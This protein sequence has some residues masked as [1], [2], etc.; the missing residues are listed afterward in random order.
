LPEIIWAAD[1]E[2]VHIPE[3][4]Q[5]DWSPSRHEFYFHTCPDYNSF[6]PLNATGTI[7][8]AASP[9]FV[10]LNLT[11][12]ET[13]CKLPM[14]TIWSP[15]GN[16]IVFSG[17]LSEEVEDSEHF[18]DVAD[19]WL[20]DRNGN[21]V[22]RV[23]PRTSAK[24]LTFH[25]W[26]DERTVVAGGWAGGGH[27]YVFDL[28]I[29]TGETLAAGSIHGSFGQSHAHY[30]PGSDGQDYWT[31]VSA[32]ALDH[33]TKTDYGY[34]LESGEHLHLLGVNFNP[35]NEEFTKEF[36]SHYE[37]WLPGTNQMLVLTWESEI[38]PYE[39]LDQT[40]KP[41]TQLQLWDVKTKEL[42]KLL[43]GNIVAGRFAPDG[44]TL[45]FLTAGSLQID[46]LSTSEDSNTLYM[47]VLDIDNKEIILSLPSAGS[48]SDNSLQFVDPSSFSP[49]G[50]YLSVVSPGFVQ[51]DDENHFNGINLPNGE[52][53][54]TTT[55]TSLFDIETRQFIHP[56]V[57]LEGTI[58]TSWSPTGELFVFQ[59]KE[60]NWAFVNM[61][62]AAITPLTSSGGMR[63]SSPQ[64]SYDG[65]YLSFTVR[66]ENNG[67]TAVIL[68][69]NR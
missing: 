14:N 22:G 7:F 16:Y 39:Y 26:S 37:D 57:N 4:H 35:T 5:V 31:R 65:R 48:F 32:V 66:D 27:T 49:N 25:G 55:Y 52:M 21:S 36:N 61:P 45:L 13:V 63:L 44:K 2:P 67:G 54:E 30:V 12:S 58:L 9:D 23:M 8:A 1:I 34:L 20:V 3:A 33:E 59:N 24:W 17:P 18:F 60:G 47:N 43:S 40:E 68:A 29:F 28:D 62:D 56:F 6:D 19:V 50:R 10:P 42:I 69:P 15:D 64:W 46:G 41:E 53:N 11:G 51:L 38:N